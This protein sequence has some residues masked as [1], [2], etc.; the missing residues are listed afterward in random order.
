MRKATFVFSA[1][2]FATSLVTLGVVLVGAKK[3]HDDVEGV[4]KKANEQIS[5][6][7]HALLDFEI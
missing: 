1:L 7:R 3:M 2:G 4:K 5:H 6:I